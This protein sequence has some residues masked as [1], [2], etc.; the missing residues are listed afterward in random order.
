MWDV[1]FVHCILYVSLIFALDSNLGIQGK[2]SS[3][4]MAYSPKP[5]SWTQ[6]LNA[7]P[8][9]YDPKQLT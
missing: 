3:Q 8:K 1:F 4:L 7:S 6:V 9:P 2:N 5:K